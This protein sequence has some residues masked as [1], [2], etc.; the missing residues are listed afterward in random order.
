M[1]TAALHTPTA[2]DDL[3]PQETSCKGI[4]PGWG[5]HGFYVCDAAGS[6]GI[7]PERGDLKRSERYPPEGIIYL[8]GFEVYRRFG[9]VTAASITLDASLRDEDDKRRIAVAETLTIEMAKPVSCLLPGYAI[10][11]AIRL[12]LGQRKEL[13]EDSTSPTRAT[14]PTALPLSG[15]A[16]CA[17]V[18]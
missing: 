18:A 5:W 13:A 9:G 2:E 10:S 8:G 17:E 16:R 15:Q 12:R 4:R 14:I 11:S 1:C 6:A 3:G 7:P